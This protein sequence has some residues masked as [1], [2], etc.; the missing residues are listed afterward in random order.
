MYI[1]AVRL[2]GALLGEQVVHVRPLR[3]NRAGSNAAGTGT[4]WPFSL[5]M[6]RSG[7]GPREGGWLSFDALGADTMAG[8]AALEAAN[9]DLPDDFRIIAYRQEQF[10][11]L[12]E[13]ETFQFSIGS[14]QKRAAVTVMQASHQALNVELVG[15]GGLGE[16]RLGGLL[17]TESHDRALEMRIEQ[18]RV[19]RGQTKHFQEELQEMA[20]TSPILP[21]TGSLLTDVSQSMQGLKSQTKHFQEE[22][23]ELTRTTEAELNKQK[24]AYDQLLR[25]QEGANQKLQAKNAERAKN[26]DGPSRHSQKDTS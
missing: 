7:E 5:Q 1:F 13:S 23:H 16:A 3:R 19:P 22:L 11:D 6:S 12:R 14:G 20:R 8:E 2:E 17:G 18:C 9:A 10:G 25:K 21:T 4:L 24:I 26:D 15:M